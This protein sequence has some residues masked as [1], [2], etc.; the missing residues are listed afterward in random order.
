MSNTVSTSTLRAQIWLK[1]LM[2]DVQDSLYFS[3]RQMMGTDANN[4][5]QTKEDL[6]SKPGDRVTFGLTLKIGGGITGDSELEGQ[7]QAI[8]SYAQS[9]LIDQMRNSVRLTGRLDEQKVA[10]DMRMDAKSQL[11]KWKVE[12]IERQI[13]MKLAGVTTL[14]LQD[15]GS[16]VYSA[17]A[18]WSN[19]PNIVPAADEAAGTGTRYV[20]AK[21][22]G[23]DAIAATDI[24]TTGLITKARV[25]ASISSLGTPSIQPLRIDGQNYYVMFVH[26]WQAYDLKTATS[27][28]WAQAQRDAQVRGGDNPIFTGSLGIWDGVILH[29]HE[30]VCKA[31]TGSAFSVSG[32]AVNSGASV[33][34]SVLCGRQ[35]ATFAECQNPNGFVEKEF[36]YDNKVGYATGLIGGIQKTAF[37]SI[38]YGIITVDTSATDLS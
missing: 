35:A 30:Y 31:Q 26:P 25:K 5:I 10:Y 20:C 37:N 36:D 1:E 29:E 9:N 18:T 4:I 11:A 6:K 32:T 27:S 3:Q 22:T 2:A 21:S 28:I 19:S 7:E 17:Q 24:L 34:R 12:F 23:I 14:T 38:D 8:T 33:F 15:T 13:F 16:V